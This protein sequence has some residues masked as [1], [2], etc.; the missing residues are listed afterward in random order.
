MQDFKRT[1]KA[2]VALAPQ[3]GRYVRKSVYAILGDGWVCHT[4]IVDNHSPVVLPTAYWR[5][6]NRLAAMKTLLAR[7]A[8]GRRDELRRPNS[9]EI[10]A[11]QIMRL[12]LTNVSAKVHKGTPIDDD[13]DY[14]SPDWA[15]EVPMRRAFGAPML[16]PRI[17]EGT[18]IPDSVH[19]LA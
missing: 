15:G 9:T 4:G 17:E 3:R 1:K 12:P 8:S 2:R 10:K 19:R 18:E 13:G 7:V 16:G 14:T 11:T 5:E 6:E